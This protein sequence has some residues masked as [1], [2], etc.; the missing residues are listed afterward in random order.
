MRHFEFINTSYLNQKNFISAQGRRNIWLILYL[1]ILVC[2]YFLWFIQPQFT[3]KQ[4]IPFFAQFFSSIVDR[5]KILLGASLTGTFLNVGDGVGQ[6]QDLCELVGGLQENANLPG[7]YT[8]AP[9][10]TG[11]F[12][13]DN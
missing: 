7:G 2:L 5:Y 10:M 9:E 4:Y 11:I 6:G 8:N 3:I 12:R 13:I 1:K